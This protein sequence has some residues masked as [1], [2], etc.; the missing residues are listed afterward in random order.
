VNPSS[1]AQCYL[2]PRAIIS[3]HRFA[4]TVLK[5][6]KICTPHLSQNSRPAEIIPE[7]TVAA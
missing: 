7:V 4:H 5:H 3:D 1:S 2:P 6:V